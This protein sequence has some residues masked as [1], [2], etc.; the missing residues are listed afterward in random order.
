MDNLRHNV[1]IL[2]AHLP[3]HCQL[4]PAVKANAYGHGAIE[5]SKALNEHGVQTFSVA[6]VLE[7][8]GL[9]DHGIKGEILILG[10][11]HPEKVNLLK[12]H[13]LTQTVM[14]LNYAKMLDRHGKKLPVHIKIDTGMRRLGEDAANIK[15]IIRI[16]N[17]KNLVINGIF[18]H[19]CTVDGSKQSDIDFAQAQINCFNQLLSKIKEHGIK[20]PKAHAQS[21]Y[22]V[23]KHPELSFDYARV[24]IALYGMLSTQED[25]TISKPGYGRFF[26]LRRGSVQL[27]PLTKANRQAMGLH[28]LPSRIQ[29]SQFWQSAM[30]TA[31]HEVCHAGLEI[32]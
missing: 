17:C 25:T 32:Y 28:L 7:G 3:K 27:K 31:S 11:T 14:D 23:F 5:I 24:G 16:F 1:D 21:S 15:N 6:T 30:Q 8:V 2:R 13:R 20:L 10:Y 9:R 26:H 29:K 22:G 18:T 4:M 19:F 12:K